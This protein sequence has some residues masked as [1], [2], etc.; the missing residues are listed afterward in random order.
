MLN[1]LKIN[2]FL[3]TKYDGN[4]T[5]YNGGGLI[6]RTSSQRWFNALGNYHIDTIKIYQTASGQT[7]S[8]LLK[9]FN[10]DITNPTQ[11]IQIKIPKEDISIRIKSL[12][13]VVEDNGNGETYL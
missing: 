10:V 11:L 7:S 5:K 8:T 1:L 12:E 9:S 13:I 6:I 4:Y 3:K 2:T